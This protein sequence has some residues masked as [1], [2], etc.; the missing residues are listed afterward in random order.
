MYR[1]LSKKGVLDKPVRFT[2]SPF[3][4]PCSLAIAL[5]VLL[6]SLFP[7]PCSLAQNDPAHGQ[8]LFAYKLLQR[9]DNELAADAFEDYLS[10]FPD[11][12]KRGDAMYYRALLHRRAGE[13]E[14]AATT[15]S[16][17]DRL[18]P[19]PEG[20]LVPDYARKLLQGQVLVDL[21]RY[22]EALRPLE[23]LR[24]DTLPAEV[25]S[26]ANYLKGVAYRGAGNLDAAA[27]A[28]NNAASADTPVRGRAQLEL[29][30]ARVLQGQSDAA[31]AAL[32][33][34]MQNKDPA[35][36][37]DAARMAGDVAYAAGDHAAATAA[38]LRVI[39]DYAST[40]NYRPAV[41]GLLWTNFAADDFR[42][43]LTTYDRYAEVLERDPTAAYLA[44]SAHQQLGQ[45]EWADRLLGQSI[46]SNLPPSPE[47]REKAL[48]KRAVSLFELGQFQKMQA[49]LNELVRDFPESALR[50]DA[51]YLLAAADAKAGTPGS[52]EAGRIG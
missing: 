26:S 48:Y 28:F 27:T 21:A 15:L 33:E 10:R 50:V 5:A 19:P 18:G 42:G 22:D 41:L 51:A 8:F 11:D 29:A 31:L 47:V 16:R 43:T 35:V 7:V 25:A 37:A 20:A 39:R 36:A 38:Y 3:P 2:C 14:Q 45:H 32:N 52:V 23:T 13:N 44:G 12:A 4:V 24:V 1:N 40:R 30:R 49:A 34:A 6:C 9:G 46:E 17:L